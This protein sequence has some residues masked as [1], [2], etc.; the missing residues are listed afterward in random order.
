VVSVEYVVS[1][2][3]SREREHS[4][5]NLVVMKEGGIKEIQARETVIWRPCRLTIIL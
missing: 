1:A 5:S 4:P 2:V 3:S